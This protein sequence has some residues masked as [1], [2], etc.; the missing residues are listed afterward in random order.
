MGKLWRM[1]FFF[2]CNL[3]LLFLNGFSTP[4]GKHGKPHFSAPFV[5]RFCPLWAGNAALKR[6]M[7][8]SSSVRLGQRQKDNGKF[9]EKQVLFHG[10]SKGFFDVSSASDAFFH[11]FHT[12]Y[13]YY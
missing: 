8:S 4:C 13:Y 6:E 12:P 7:V 1:R 3:I 2:L 10:F 5:E 11:G 9:L